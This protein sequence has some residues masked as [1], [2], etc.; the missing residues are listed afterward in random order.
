AIRMMLAWLGI[1]ALSF[2]MGARFERVNLGAWISPVETVLLLG[3][4]SWPWLQKKLGRLYL[5]LALGVATFSP[6]IGNVIGL[7]LP[8]EGELQLA[9]LGLGQWQLVIVLLM[10][11]ILI[12]WQYGFRAVVGYSLATALLDVSLAA[13]L[14]DYDQSAEKLFILVSIVVFRTLFYLLIGYAIA[15]LAAE[16]RQQNRRLEQANRELSSYAMAL[17]Q[18]TIS[19]ER[20][21]LARELH[22]T[23]AHTLSGLAVQLEAVEALWES[24]PGSARQM[25]T[26][27]LAQ[28]RRG[29]GEIRR[30]IQALR[31][32]P[33]EDLGL[34]LALSSLIRTEA[35]RG[36]LTL[37]LDMPESLPYLRPEVEHGLYR[38]TEEALRNVV[39][40][41]RATS[42][43]ACLEPIDG[44]LG[45]TLKDDGTGFDASQP[46]V[47]D[48][49]GLRGMQERAEAIGGRL[50]VQSSPGQG[51]TVQLWIE[52]RP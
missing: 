36:G 42:L 30:A 43:W 44:N 2:G 45:L 14:Y 17:E 11:L 34:S 5:P 48:S 10:P 33:L 23:L 16:Q 12:S 39:R 8:P 3:Y 29:L 51:T 40:H 15:R 37:H 7:D 25:H 50:D 47:D 52:V 27:S 49:Y 19:R 38:I 31:A 28:T 35:E 6:V 46:P 20:N 13:L 1:I 9:R 32:E 18:L 26:N 24:D 21:R 41:A 22:D 4:L